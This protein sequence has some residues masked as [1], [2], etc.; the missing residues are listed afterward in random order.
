MDKNTVVWSEAQVIPLVNKMES[1]CEGEGAI[2][3]TTTQVRTHSRNSTEHQLHIKDELLIPYQNGIHS[4]PEPYGA[5]L[6]GP[7]SPS[8]PVNRTPSLLDGQSTHRPDLIGNIPGFGNNPQV[9]L[10]EAGRKQL[11]G[12]IQQLQEQLQMNLLQQTFLIQTGSTTADKKSNSPMQAL[13]LQQQHLMQ[14]LQL[15]QRHYLMSLHAALPREAENKMDASVW[16]S[17]EEMRKITTTRDNTP[18][19][20]PNQEKSSDDMSGSIT[21]RSRTSSEELQDKPNKVEQE[22][23]HPLFG[24]GLCRWPGCETSCEDFQ[25]FISHLNSEHIIDDRSTAQVRV[26]MQVVSQLEVQLERERERL[27]AMMLHLQVNPKGEAEPPNGCK[28]D[29]TLANLQPD[30]SSMLSLP[31]PP[32]M[33]STLSNLSR[34]SQGPPPRQHHFMAPPTATCPAPVRRRV[35]DKANSSMSSEI[36]RNREFYRSADVRPPFTYASLIRQ[37]IVESPEKQLTLNEIYNWF[38][39]TFCYF[40]RNAATWKNAVRHNL[41]L[42]KCFM[43]V[44]NVKGAVWTVDEAE[45]YRRRHQRTS[46]GGNVQARSP[47]QTMPALYGASFSTTLKS[48]LADGNLNFLQRSANLNGFPFLGLPQ[49]SLAVHSGNDTTSEPPTKISSTGDG[50]RPISPSR[51]FDKDDDFED[52]KPDRAYN[53]DDYRDFPEEENFPRE[54]Q[55]AKMDDRAFEFCSVKKEGDPSYD[56]YRNYE[57]ETRVYNGNF[58]AISNRDFTAMNHLKLEYEREFLQAAKNKTAVPATQTEGQ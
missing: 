39:N 16:N 46:S 4:S 56:F 11:E 9:Q 3:L 48:A 7:H 15:A 37:A 12:V 49:K 10:A 18:S 5:K 43:R 24:H 45:F 13:A 31:V 58:S 52:Y 38:Q 19:P 2:N 28:R 1:D 27:Q 32:Y 51:S 6:D 44:E 14:H 21:S 47:T 54:K 30:P 36:N 41:S 22:K 23:S 29:T 34:G 53:S 25:T 35:S 17:S 40:R 20:E 57:S 33:S 8:S 50:D 42:H 26:Q 55:D